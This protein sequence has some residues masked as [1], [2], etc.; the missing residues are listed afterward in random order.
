MILKPRRNQNFQRR[1]AHIILNRLYPSSDLLI[2]RIIEH[3]R[4]VVLGG[5][6]L[7]SLNGEDARNQNVYFLSVFGNESNEILSSVSKKVSGE[8]DK[9]CV[10]A[11][12]DLVLSYRQKQNLQKPANYDSI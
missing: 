1:E 11:T 12:G 2:V 7:S 8:K 9:F 6:Y 5:R 10:G 3:P 4:S